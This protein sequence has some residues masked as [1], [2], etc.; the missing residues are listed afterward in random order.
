MRGRRISFG[1]CKAKQKQTSRTILE[2]NF[3]I[4]AEQQRVLAK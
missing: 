2:D 4:R 1:C 3:L